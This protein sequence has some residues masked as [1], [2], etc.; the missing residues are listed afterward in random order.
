MFDNLGVAKDLGHFLAVLVLDRCGTSQ[1]G[2]GPVE[3]IV[4]QVLFPAC[5]Q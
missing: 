2:L 3:A 1:N 4:G 5:G